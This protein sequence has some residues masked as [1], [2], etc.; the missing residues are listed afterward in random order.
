MNWNTPA[1]IM[2]AAFIGLG[3]PEPELLQ[4]SELADIVFQRLAFYYEGLRSSDQNLVSKWTSEFQ[5]PVDASSVNLSTLTANDILMP[6]WAE[7]RQTSDP[8]G[9][10]EFLPAVNLDTLAEKRSIGEAAV[11]F[12][13]GNRTGVM[14][15]FSYFGN[16][17]SPPAATFRVRYAPVGFGHTGNLSDNVGLPDNFTPMLIADVKLH[18]ISL[19]QVNASKYVTS[20]PEL[21]A[22]MAAWNVLAQQMM[23]DREEWNKLYE[24]YIRRSRTSGRARNRSDVLSGSQLPK[25]RRYYG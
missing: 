25:I 8:D 22:R 13:G 15:E 5:L 19:L 11:A 21:Q 9:I 7:R 10:W 4:R 6:L 12:T 2:S 14:A 23:M 1:K 16:E 24:S 17:V 3:Q 18:A 20:R